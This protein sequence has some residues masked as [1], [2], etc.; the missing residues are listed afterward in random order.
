M[1]WM[2]FIHRVRKKDGLK[3]CDGPPLIPDG[4]ADSIQMTRMQVDTRCK[5]GLRAP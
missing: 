4:N 3:W 2:A 1:K 5:R